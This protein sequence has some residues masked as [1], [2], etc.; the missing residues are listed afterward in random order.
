MPP[1]TYRVH[2]KSKN[3]LALKSNMT[4]KMHPQATLKMFP[5]DKPHYTVLRISDAQDVTVTGGTI[6]GDRRTHKG[7]G[8]EWGMGIFNM[9]GSE[10]VTISN[11]RALQQRGAKAALVAPATRQRCKPHRI[12]VAVLKWSAKSNDQLCGCKSGL[13]LGKI[14]TLS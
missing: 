13:V 4:F 11:V 14:W 1:G 10:R 5:T 6:V 8:G 2:T 3:R 12:F 9:K 7:K